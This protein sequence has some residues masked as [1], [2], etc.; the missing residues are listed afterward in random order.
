MGG[1]YTAAA[2]GLRPAGFEAAVGSGS[3][4][5]SRFGAPAHLAFVMDMNDIP[6]AWETPKAVLE[7]RLRNTDPEA[8]RQ[9]LRDRKE[10]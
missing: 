10:A 9:F 1:D 2:R 4:G 6:W 3:S 7:E 8:Y 5:V